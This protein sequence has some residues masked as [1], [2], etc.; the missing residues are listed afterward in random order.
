MALAAAS[1]AIVLAPPSARAADD[2]NVRITTPY[3]AIT[4]EAGATLKFDLDARAPQPE[5][6]DLRVDGTPQGWT[7]ILRGGGFVIDGLTARPDTASNAQLEVDIPASARPGQYPIDVTETAPQGS[8]VDH[9]TITVASKVDSGVGL[10]A[11]FTSLKGGPT[12]SFSYNL[13]ITNNTP[14]AQ[15]Y[16][17]EGSGPQGW[18]VTVSPQA[19][20]RANTV[21]VEAGATSTIQVSAKG[22]DGVKAGK[23][24]ITVKVTDANGA[25]GSIPL[26]AEVTGT[27]QL[28]M[29]TADQRLN[30]S[31]HANHTSKETIVVTNSGTAPLDSVNL[32]ASPPSGWQVTFDP[33]T[34]NNVGPGDNVQVVAQIRP[35]KDALAGDYAMTLSGTGGSQSAKLDVRYSVTSG[36]SWVLIG[37]A[38]IVVAV[39][40]V[41]AA[42]RRF[43]HR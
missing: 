24:P 18:T 13:T 43:G 6:V 27:P 19:Q 8:S 16:N 38:V 29:A 35:S 11:D 30:F 28:Q 37:L 34:V 26:T 12:D 7:T 25:S 15:T 21:T 17:F 14:T 40:A 32:T 10:T 23:Y 9:L 31:G 42:Y 36:R 3:P 39:L 1:A 20:S 33:P 4:V 41:A 2:P 5:R 22:P